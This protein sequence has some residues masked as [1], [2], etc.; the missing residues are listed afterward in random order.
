MVFW[1]MVAVAVDDLAIHRNH[2]TR[3]D[4]DEVAF[5]ESTGR[6]RLTTPFLRTQ[7][8]FD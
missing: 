8:D 1:S 2:L 6:D 5:F 3:V 4:H 7:A